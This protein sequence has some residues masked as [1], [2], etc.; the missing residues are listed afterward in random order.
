MSTRIKQSLFKLDC[1]SYEVEVSIRLWSQYGVFSIKATDKTSKLY[2][3]V[4]NINGLAS[5][6][7]GYDPENP[8]MEN[9][10]WENKTPK[11]KSW[12]AEAKEFL[13]DGQFQIYFARCL[14]EDRCAG[15]WDNI[16]EEAR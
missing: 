14:D 7:S 11:V 9:S 3:Y 2:S 6:F 13:S 1:C 15:E 4:T 10:T 16:L 5:Q 12:Y 8:A